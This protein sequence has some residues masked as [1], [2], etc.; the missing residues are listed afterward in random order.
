MRLWEAAPGAATQGDAVIVGE[1][2]GP[3]VLRGGDL[4]KGGKSE[5]ADFF[6]RQTDFTGDTDGLD[7]LTPRSKDF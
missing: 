5:R 3:M 6:N 7:G 1:V 2:W 4:G